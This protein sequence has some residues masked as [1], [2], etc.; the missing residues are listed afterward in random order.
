M[1]DE[2]C[3]EFDLDDVVNSTSKARRVALEEHSLRASLEEVNTKSSLR[4]YASLPHYKEGAR[5]L[6]VAKRSDR[7]VIAKFRLYSFKW[8]SRK[9]DG[10]RV[11]A[12]CSE[13]ETVEHLIED[14]RGTQG[15]ERDALLHRGLLRSED[16]LNVRERESIEDVAKYL[17][18]I[19]T[20][21]K[22]YMN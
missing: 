18:S 12:L 5:Y 1:Y 3:G 22:A 8:E 2:L 11:C 21:R 15:T 19:L 13:N 6:N 20:R 16:I 4:L 9:V 10:V 7:H 14:C 17:Y